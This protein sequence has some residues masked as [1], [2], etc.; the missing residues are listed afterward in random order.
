MEGTAENG[1]IAEGKRKQ[2]RLTHR[3]GGITHD[4]AAP[5]FCLCGFL[6]SR[7]SRLGFR[8]LDN[9]IAEVS[10]FKSIEEKQ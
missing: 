10:I 5:L 7:A 8:A 3:G 4:T 1:T 6:L 2:H 9:A